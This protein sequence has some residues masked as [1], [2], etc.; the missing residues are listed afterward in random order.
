[1]YNISERSR[2]K[3]SIST[4][5]EEEADKNTMNISS[6]PEKSKEDNKETNSLLITIDVH[7]IPSTTTTDT[8]TTTNAN[9]NDSHNTKH[10]GTYT[11]RGRGYKPLV[12]LEEEKQTDIN[13]PDDATINTDNNTKAAVNT[14]IILLDK[15]NTEISNNNKKEHKKN[16]LKINQIFERRKRGDPST[17]YINDKTKKSSESVETTSVIPSI[18]TEDPKSVLHSK[19]STISSNSNNK[20]FKAK[21]IE[22]FDKNSKQSNSDTIQ[23]DQSILNHNRTVEIY[24]GDE[25]QTERD[26]TGIVF[27]DGQMTSSHINYQRTRATYY[28]NQYDHYFDNQ[29][30]NIVIQIH[31]IHGSEHNYYRN[32][33]N[34]RNSINNSINNNSNNMINNNNT[35]TTCTTLSSVSTP[36]II[37]I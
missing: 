17:K 8:T 4:K 12:H 22:E 21:K 34:Y 26:V 32:T 23:K 13:N 16:Y 2:S 28:D 10:R 14:A 15:D 31:Q 19:S 25:E 18:T 6:I 30:D 24:F 5:E 3:N 29:Y 7:S 35:T 1:M 20:Q 11:R 37:I 27:P 36:D 9:I 33:H